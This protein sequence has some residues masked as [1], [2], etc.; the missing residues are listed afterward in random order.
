MRKVSKDLESDPVSGGRGHHITDRCQIR[1]K[2]FG[3]KPPQGLRS[4]CAITFFLNAYD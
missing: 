3:K 1:T 2:G 4:R